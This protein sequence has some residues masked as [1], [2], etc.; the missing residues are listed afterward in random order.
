MGWK[1]ELPD[2]R[3]YLYKHLNEF[4]VDRLP[5][6]VDLRPHCPSV[7][8]QG[9]ASSCTANAIAG[10]LEFDRIKQ[11]INDFKPSRLF[12]YYN[13]RLIEGD[14]SG[15][16]GAYIRDGIKAIAT[17]GYPD[18]SIW[19]YDLNNLDVK[20]IQKAYNSAKKFRAL[21]YYLLDNSD[22]NSLK[23]CLAAG[24][25]FVIGITVCPSFDTNDYNGGMVPLPGSSEVPEGGHAVAIVG[26]RNSTQTFILRNSWG[27]GVGENG[28]YHIPY[29]Y[30]TNSNLASDC[31]TIRTTS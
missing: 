5:D 12:I 13:E 31:W 22:L 23:S 10:L 17:Y 2:H 6:W 30:L 26:Y 8:D 1:P 18:E 21:N 29:A 4:K 15:D 7:Y 25:P 16:N 14:V 11:G 24:F 19:P 28:Y 3:D 27:T 9:Q 20:P